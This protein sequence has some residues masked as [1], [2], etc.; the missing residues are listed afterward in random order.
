MRDSC[1]LDTNVLIVA[2]AADPSSSITPGVTPVGDVS[3]CESVLRWLIEFAESDQRW[4]LDSLG[5]IES[6]YR[7]SRRRETKLTEQDFAFLVM[8]DKIT[9][10]LVSW[11]EIE[12]DE[13]DNARIPM[14]LDKVV[15]DLADRKMVAAVLAAINLGDNAQLVNACDTDWYDWEVELFAEGVKVKQLLD[16]WLRKVWRDKKKK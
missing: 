7:G 14:K 5:L 1:V 10:D 3:M 2:M 16:P 9:R 11:I 4:V 12:L 8:K 13:H 6:E 15:T